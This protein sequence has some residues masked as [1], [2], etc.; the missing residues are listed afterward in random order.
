MYENGNQRGSQETEFSKILSDTLLKTYEYPFIVIDS[1]YNIKKIQ[2]YSNQL[3]A[4]FHDKEQNNLLRGINDQFKI[5][6]EK[7]TANAFKDNRMSET[8]A[9]RI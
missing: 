2:D 4:L 5:P 9:Y 8:G 3:S 7:A 1:D 6:L